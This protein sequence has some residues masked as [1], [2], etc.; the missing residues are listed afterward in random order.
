MAASDGDRRRERRGHHTRCVSTK[1]ANLKSTVLDLVD[2]TKGSLG[3]FF[4]NENDAVIAAVD[5]VSLIS[6]TTLVKYATVFPTVHK[7]TLLGQL[8]FEAGRQA[9]DD[10]GEPRRMRR[11]RRAR[12]WRRGSGARNV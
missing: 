3:K 4:T 10:S 9:L 12:R 6:L 1:L 2:A 7:L 11:R 5:R 8:L